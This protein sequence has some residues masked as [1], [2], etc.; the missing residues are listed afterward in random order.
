MRGYLLIQDLK[1]AD[2]MA[3]VSDSSDAL[4]EGLWSINDVCSGVD[5]STSSKK[6]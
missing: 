2:D 3:I 5:I 1:Y 4:E 6:K